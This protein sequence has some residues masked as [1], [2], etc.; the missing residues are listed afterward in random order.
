[1]NATNAACEFISTLSGQSREL[2]KEKEIQ[3]RHDLIYNITKNESKQ[4][5]AD[6]D[7]GDDEQAIGPDDFVESGGL[8]DSDPNRYI[9][10]STMTTAEVE[11]P[12]TYNLHITYDQ[13]FQMLFVSFLF[14]ANN[15]TPI[16]CSSEQV[17]HETHQIR[18]E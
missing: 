9:A 4:A 6:A 2:L 17:N 3:R 5:G 11:K 16:F 14:L 13:Y 10:Q 8:G 18:C 15:T 7:D 1:M 12:R